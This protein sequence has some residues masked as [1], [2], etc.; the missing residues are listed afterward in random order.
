MLFNK[1]IVELRFQAW[2]HIYI[3][4][5]ETRASIAP[6]HKSIFVSIKLTDEFKSS[7]GR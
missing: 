3:L 5:V 2:L 6:E 1:G 4:K 7:P